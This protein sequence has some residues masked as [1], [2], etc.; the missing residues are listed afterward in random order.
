[1]QYAVV[2]GTSRGLGESI[3]KKLM[4]IGIHI[5]GVSRNENEGLALYAKE[6]G[7][8]YVHV[9][10]DIRNPKQVEEV[11]TKIGETVFDQRPELVYLI[12]NAGV[13]EPIDH[14]GNLDAMKL[15]DHVN[16]NLLAPMVI[17]N[18][19]L[20]RAEQTATCLITVNVTSGAGESA[21]YGWSAYCSTKAG[22]NRYTETVALE[23]E[24]R[25][26]NNKTIAFSPGIMDTKMQDQ[27]R[28]ST[29]DAFKEVEKFK[30]YKENNLLKSTD[31][32]AG[33]LADLL[34]D[35]NKLQNG[36]IYYVKELL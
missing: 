7:T 34:R 36:K 11:F 10:C 25:G 18:L 15:S 27:I 26:T 33:A 12:N 24:E 29:E 5:I 8:S 13:V 19:F 16:V 14:V 3:A 35:G 1:M 6:C 30:Q 32:I 23:Q 17:T 31:R 21:V 22:L 20:Q 9:P 28:S 2:T 4:K